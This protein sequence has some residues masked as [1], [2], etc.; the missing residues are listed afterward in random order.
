MID[1][2][3][4]LVR[5]LSKPFQYIWYGF[6]GR[7][8]IE[9]AVKMRLFFTNGRHQ[10]VWMLDWEKQGSNFKWT[11]MPY[12][13]PQLATMKSSDELEALIT[14]KRQFVLIVKAK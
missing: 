13:Y 11:Q 2:F 9:E 5:N 1:L 6:K 4:W 10:D 7:L 12:R 14:L 8:A 3:A